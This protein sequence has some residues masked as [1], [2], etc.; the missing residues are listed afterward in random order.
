[1]DWGGDIEFLTDVSLRRGE[2]TDSLKKM[3]TLDPELEFVWDL[4]VI[5]NRGRTSH[6]S[7]A[8]EGR[9]YMKPDNLAVG[10]ILN[11]LGAADITDIDQKF[12][13]LKMVQSMDTA[14]IGRATSGVK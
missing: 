3:P 7:L 6:I 2:L 9:K 11:L 8:S 1:M 10:E 12:R 5:L 14:Y 4:F 13:V